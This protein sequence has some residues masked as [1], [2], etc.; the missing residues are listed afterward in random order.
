VNRRSTVGGSGDRGYARRLTVAFALAIGLHEAIAG[1]LPR[2]GFPPPEER[3]VAARTVTLA[4][5]PR[6]TPKPTPVPTPKATP[7]ITPAPHYTLAPQTVVRAPAPRAA[8][9]PRTNAGGAAAHR[10]VLRRTIV[11]RTAP[12][13][14]P[15]EGIHAGVQNGGS[16]T[17]AG[18]GAGNGGLGGTGTG[19]GGTGTGNGGETNSSP[20]GAVYLLPAGVTFRRDGTVVQ[21]VLAKIVLGD[22]TVEVG[23][24]PY[25]FTYPAERSNPF[26]HEEALSPDKGIPVQQPPEGTDMSA[27]PPAV[28]IVLK[29][30]NP[31]TGTTTLKDCPS[32]SPAS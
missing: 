26:V 31:A 18:P 4:R 29:Y 28:Q 13:Q 30:T 1:F 15:A 8:A 17:G 27:A 9:T 23:R 10:R 16:G 5:R 19:T 25:P 20:C 21:T 24:F 22:G 7:R 11:A 3:V 6:P 32:A 2:R 12:P 14:S